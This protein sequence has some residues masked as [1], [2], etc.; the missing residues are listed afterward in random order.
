MPVTQPAGA[1]TTLASGNFV[2]AVFSLD[3]T[4]IYLVSGNT[5]TAVN[6]ATG[7]VVATYTMGTS[8]GGADLSPDGQYLAV[9]ETHP[10]TNEG[11]LYR[12]DLSNGTVGT[13]TIAGTFALNDVAFLAD[14]SVIVSQQFAA[15]LRIAN[16][17]TSTSYDATIAV[18]PYAVLTESA[19]STYVLAQ[20]HTLTWPLYTLDW[21]HGSGYLLDTN[22]PYAGA[23]I[24]PPD[25]AVGAVSPDGSLVVQ[26]STLRVYDRGL[27]R[28][29]TNLG[30]HFPYLTDTAGL[31]FS[32]DGA[33]LYVATRDGAVV[34][35]ST[36]TW[37][38]VAAYPIGGSPADPGRQP[39]PTVGYGDILQL[40]PDGHHLSVITTAGIQ[41]VDLSH[42][43]PVATAGADNI[44]GAGLLYG[45]GGDD[46]LSSTG[47]ASMHGGDGNDTLVS[48]SGGD[49]LDGGAGVDTASYQSAASAVTVDLATAGAQPNGD[50]LVS[51]ENLTG[52]AFADT[53]NG[54]SHDNVL[55]GGDGN[56][57]LSGESGNDT[58][59]G[60][61][62]NDNIDG[63]DGNDYIDG[64]PGADTMFGGIGGDDTYVVNDVGDTVSEPVGF[65]TN[66]D[67]NYG[68]DI[69]LASISFVLPNVSGLS[70]VGFI[71]NL[72]LT[73]SDDI[74]GTGNALDNVIVGN[75]AANVI[76]AGAGADALTGGLG[77]D[78][79]TGG[80]QND[81]F[82]DTAA[83]LDGDTITDLSPGDRVVI[84]DATMVGFSFSLSAN[85]LTYTG[86]SLTIGNHLNGTIV[87]SAAAGGG[88]E[89]SVVP[90][91]IDDFN[92]DHFSD[93]L[94]RNDSG[95]VVTFLGQPN[96]AFVGNVN[97]NLNP[98]TDWH[99]AGTGDFNGDGYA[100]I[101]W[102]SDSGAVVDLLGQSNGAFVGNVNF[103]LNPGTDWHIA[104]TGDFNGDGFDDILWRSDSGAVVD[105]LG[106]SNGAFVGNVNFNLNPGT[107]W[108]IAGT[109]DFNGDGYDD[110][111]W[112][113]DGGAVVD[114]LGQA[115][116]AFVGNVNFNLNP[117]TDWHIAGTG[118]F[119]G[120][121]YDDILWRSDSGAITDLLGQP[122]GAFVGNVANLDVNPGTDWYVVSIGDFNGD[123]MDDLLLRNGSGQT[124][125]WLGLA[126]GSFSDNSPTFTIN[127]GTDWHVQNAVVHDPLSSA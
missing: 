46:L 111:L 124:T 62:G 68:D 105:L 7:S 31:A 20:P 101:L 88:V 12:L 1:I 54:D 8:L 48:G 82:I 24:S 102:R 18:P 13:Y 83:G 95:S 44:S 104:G 23:A 93:V 121:G 117:G 69:V 41:V 115:N 119:N 118:D 19:N 47:L 9:V 45:L 122:S 35:F 28:M 17:Q 63:G 58:I 26:G 114:L 120:D 91:P 81:T 40:S 94:W 67:G 38:A 50:T 36:S 90:H 15:P 76:S 92:G 112:R 113:S 16:L 51:V 33:T 60:G 6:V 66:G 108:H 55:A 11:V 10:V 70:H 126:D 43:V 106:Q 3:G 34:Q 107:D 73:G 25:T 57:A 125:D 27:D 75:S 103:N 4:K 32:A 65:G 56:D 109:G 79:L 2:D 30:T 78:T 74:N 21:A 61:A 96:G 59:Y 84:T 49:V 39:G 64:G 22:D 87:A 123:G 5:V 97:F 29:V 71:E 127:P 110:I 72:T 89:L 98:G 116:G 53:L 99:I 37:D 42:A 52:S 85:T 100:D 80:S 77:A 14:G 86:G